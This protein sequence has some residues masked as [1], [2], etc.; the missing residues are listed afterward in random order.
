[1]IDGA[2]ALQDALDAVVPGHALPAAFALHPAIHALEVERIWRRSWLLGALSA[3]LPQPGDFVRVELGE[4]DSVI[5]Q[6]DERGAVHGLHNT[7]RH[8][9]MPV[10]DR[11][12]GQARHWVCPYH[13]WSYGLDGRLLGDGGAGL[14]LDPV[15]FGLRTAPVREISGLVLVWLGRE[16]PDDSIEQA[17]ADL[18][19]PLA[20]QGLHRAAVAHQIDYA[21]HANWKLVWENNRECWHCHAGHPE[22][23]QANFDAAPDTERNR[24]RAWR[25]AA[26]HRELLHGED[27]V[28]VVP[29][30]DEPGLFAFPTPGRWWSVNRTP[31]TE[32]FVTESLDGR[33]VGPLMGDYRDHDVGTLRF[34]GVPGFWCHASADHAVVTRLLPDGPERTRI[35]VSWL[36]DRDARPGRDYRLERMLPFW[37][38]TSE[39]D[40]GLCE[41]NHRGVRNPAFEPGPYVAGREDNL[42]ALQQWY[43]ERIAR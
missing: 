36:V 43:L 6:R 17:A 15:A 41:A 38:L 28:A 22:Y 42:V 27:P 20:V 25:R 4:G 2:A 13:Q 37:Q 40:W 14:A 7:C 21:V 33:P 16:A 32:G 10:C 18:A 29:R 30:H 26:R 9:G 3:E 11:P 23:V 12:S 34:R 19:E 8:R 24:E 35:R 1:V 31:L 5:L 39:Q